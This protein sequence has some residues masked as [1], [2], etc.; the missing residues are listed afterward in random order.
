MKL[1]IIREALTIKIIDN[2][3]QCG[4]I[5]GEIPMCFIND[6]TNIE[7]MCDAEAE[8]LLLLIYQ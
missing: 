8:I 5:R 4:G 3:E 6:V 1:L 7:E 2:C